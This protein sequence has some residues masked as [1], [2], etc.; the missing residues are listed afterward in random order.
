MCELLKCI[1]TICIIFYSELMTSALY[2]DY[3][4]MIFHLF[5]LMNNGR[6]GQLAAD[7]LGQ[8]LTLCEKT[9][10][11][12]RLFA[13]FHCIQFDAQLFVVPISC[14]C[15]FCLFRSKKAVQIRHWFKAHFTME[16]G[17]GGK[18]PL[19]GRRSDPI[20]NF[21]TLISTNDKKGNPLQ[22]QDFRCNSCMTRVL[23]RPER[24][25]EHREKCI[26]I[27]VITSE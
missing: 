3:Q 13:R 19:S 12:K 21:F 14:F 8:T 25:R 1:Y 11:V 6:Q 24:M 9:C 20:W 7:V 17:S 4:I 15:A 23:G 22:K 18:R 16:G 26:Q 27:N 5:N 2:I 10:D